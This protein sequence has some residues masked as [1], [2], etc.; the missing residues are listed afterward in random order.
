[1]SDVCWGH[2]FC[3]HVGIRVDLSF[4]L[5]NGWITVSMECGI[6]EYLF[7]FCRFEF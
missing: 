7:I 3:M 6:L 5:L 2:F 1:M 4:D